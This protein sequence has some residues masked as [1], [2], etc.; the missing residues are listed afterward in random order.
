MKNV[1]EFCNMN[2]YNRISN[3]GS[4]KL[5]ENVSKLQNLTYLNVYLN[6]NFRL[7]LFSFKFKIFQT[8]KL[9]K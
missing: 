1:I 9:F 7:N 8:I 5:C 2:R 6:K 4:I 3:E